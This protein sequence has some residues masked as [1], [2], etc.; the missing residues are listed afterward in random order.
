LKRFISLFVRSL[1][2]IIGSKP[3]YLPCGEV[4]ES[5]EYYQSRYKESI[6]EF[7]RKPVEIPKKSHRCLYVHQSEV[8]ININ[9]IDYDYIGSDD[10]TTCHIVIARD[11]L[12]RRLLI[13]HI[14]SPEIC[15]EL[16]SC[17]NNLGDSIDIYVYG[18][19]GDE[20]SVSITEAL[21][22]SLKGSTV[23]CYLQLLAVHQCRCID[24]ATT[25]LSFYGIGICKSIETGRYEVCPVHFPID[26]RGPEFLVRNAIAESSNV[27]KR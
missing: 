20:L 24:E 3:L 17:M 15:S 4:F 2:H 25:R 5:V 10:A 13:C 8:A 19:I 11:G 27:H 7:S 18:G 6:D 23:S 12:T 9:E 22:M 14:D 21:V 1:L 16:V 26:R